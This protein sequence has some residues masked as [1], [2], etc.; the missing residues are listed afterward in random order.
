MTKFHDQQV[1]HRPSKRTQLSA[2]ERR[3]EMEEFVRTGRH[4]DLHTSNEPK[5]PERD[6]IRVRTKN[7]R[8]LTLPFNL[9]AAATGKL[10]PGSPPQ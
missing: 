3:R 5:L 4:P 2:K 6:P 7:F 10:R 8:A 1:A 9:A